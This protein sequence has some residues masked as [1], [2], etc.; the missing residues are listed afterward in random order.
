MQSKLAI[1]QSHLCEQWSYSHRIDIEPMPYFPLRQDELHQIFRT[2]LFN[3]NKKYLRSRYFPKWKP[4][5]KFWV[6]G[7]R[8]GGYGCI[9]E[10]H[11]HLL[12]HS[13][14]DLSIQGFS[15]LVF[16]FIEL[17]GANPFNGKRRKVWEHHKDL[18]H[19]GNEEM[20]T[21]CLLNLEKVRDTERSVRYNTREG[22]PSLKKDD[23][24][25]I[26]ICE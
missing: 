1:L 9:S 5:D 15:D 6:L 2:I 23:L 17:A 12:L 4:E 24:F 8:Q 18:Y 25:F 14:E 13:P 20:D 26:G 19:I 10:Q 7:C 16:P 11:Y 21:K 22:D 3:L